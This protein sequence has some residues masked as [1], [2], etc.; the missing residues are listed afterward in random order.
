MEEEEAAHVNGGDQTAHGNHVLD[1]T[2]FDSSQES[3]SSEEFAQINHQNQNQNRDQTK[4]SE[5]KH[6][7]QFVNLM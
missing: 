6:M 3:S 4:L 7:Q 5:I 2:I 1:E